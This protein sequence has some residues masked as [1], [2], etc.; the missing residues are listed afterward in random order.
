MSRYVGQGAPAIRGVQDRV[1]LVE[2]Q[3]KGLVDPGVVI[4]D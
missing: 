4:D 2:D 1:L 3:M